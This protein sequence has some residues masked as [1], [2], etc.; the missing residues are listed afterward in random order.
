MFKNRRNTLW[1]AGCLLVF[2]VTVVAMYFVALGARVTSNV[3]RA[4]MKPPGPPVTL[5]NLHLVMGD[6]PVAPSLAL[7]ETATN[8]PALRL[9]AGMLLAGARGRW[10]LVFR[11]AEPY[12][13]VTGWY[14]RH[15]PGWYRLPVDDD[16]AARRSNGILERVWTRNGDHFLVAYL[17]EHP[18]EIILIVSSP[19]PR[20]RVE[21]AARRRYLHNSTQADRYSTEGR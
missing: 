17:P 11:S 13:T 1:G 8:D 18:G 7:D 5:S 12:G 9:Q 16:L 20:K 4:G 14:R 19:P 3:L 6:V 21:P 2:A 15:L 10:I